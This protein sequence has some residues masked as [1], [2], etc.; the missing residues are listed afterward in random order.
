MIK[1][2]TSAVFFSTDNGTTV[3]R[4]ANAT[5]EEQNPLPGGITN[6][7]RFDESQSNNASLSSLWEADASRFTMSGNT[8]LRDGQTAGFDSPGL[9]YRALENAADLFTETDRPL[10]PQQSC[11]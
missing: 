2:F 3:Q 6:I 5:E 9:L 11:G 8:V 7:F 4:R 1:P 10:A